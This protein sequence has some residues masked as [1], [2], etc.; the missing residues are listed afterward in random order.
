MQLSRVEVGEIWQV[1]SKCRENMF[2]FILC[3]NVNACIFAVELVFCFLSGDNLGWVIHPGIW[4]TFS[5]NEAP[6]FH[7]K[8]KG[9]ETNVFGAS[10]F[11]YFLHSPMLFDDNRFVQ[12]LYGVELISKH[13][14]LLFTFFMLWNKLLLEWFRKSCNCLW[15][16]QHVHMYI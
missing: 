13:S 7:P 1:I 4:G 16:I 5:L 6:I 2:Y 15:Y 9:W 14:V 10:R 8:Y 3:L 12:N 11:K